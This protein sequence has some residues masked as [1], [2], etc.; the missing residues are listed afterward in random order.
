MA[1]ANGCWRN[2]GVLHNEVPNIEVYVGFQT[3]LQLLFLAIGHGEY[4]RNS[5]KSTRIFQIQPRRTEHTMKEKGPVAEE[6]EGNANV[7]V[8]CTSHNAAP[9]YPCSMSHFP[10]SHAM[11][12]QS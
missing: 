1:T 11:M 8:Q 6:V 9:Q 7:L 10:L 2:L 12:P 4:E 3:L 5:V